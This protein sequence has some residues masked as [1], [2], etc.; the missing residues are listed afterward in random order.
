M[1]V[2]PK[3]KGSRRRP[4]GG[5]P[6]ISLPTDRTPVPMDVR[7]YIT[8]FY[9]PPGVGK[10]TFV[11][12]M[13]DKVLFLSTD[14]GTRFL[15]AYRV[16]CSSAAHFAVAAR[17][18]AGLG[19]AITER[20]DIVC[21][22]HVD[23]WAYMAEEKVCSDL[24]IASLS[25]A[26]WGKGWK[27]LRVEMMSLLSV[28][29]GLNVG[30]VFIAHET[31]KEVK[32]RTISVDRTMPD[33]GKTSWKAI[34]PL[35]DLVGYC[36]FRTIKVAGKRKEVRV[37]ETVPREDLYVKDRTQRA[38]PTKGYEPLDGAKFVTTFK[39]GGTGSPA[40]RKRHGRRGN[41]G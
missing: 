40:G 29:K 16:E 34:I 18:L 12:S 17:E 13:S 15:P 23:D 4:A 10:T 36:G 19:D 28:L 7:K 24:G 33:M 38:R 37:L 26:Q 6:T 11:N 30:I 1:P 2:K 25:E 3:K 39:S 20:Y 27:A 8:L 41:Q 22:D 9:G 5:A 31:I 21:I 32:N 14:R 35:V